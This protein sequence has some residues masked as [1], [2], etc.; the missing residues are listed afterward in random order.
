MT[1]G[2]R[3]VQIW[4]VL[5]SAAHDRRTVTYALLAEWIGL[6]QNLLAQPL[7]MVARYCAL[8]QLPPLTVLVVQA[9]VGRPAAGFTWASDVDFAREAVFQRAWYALRPPSANDF[10]LTEHMSTDQPL[11]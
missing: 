9:D 6:G 3:A 7:G 2:E 1:S 5:V 10:T 11:D 4:Q 8:R